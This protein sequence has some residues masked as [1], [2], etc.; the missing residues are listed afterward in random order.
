M[1]RSFFAINLWTNKCRNWLLQC[2]IIG[3]RE[4]ANLVVQLARFFCQYIIGERERANLVVQLARNFGIYIYVYPGLCLSG[5]APGPARS[6][7]SESTEAH[8]R[9]LARDRARRRERLA[10]E[11]A[12]EKERRLSQRRVSISWIAP[13]RQNALALMYAVMFYVILNTRKRLGDCVTFLA[14]GTL[15]MQRLNA[16]T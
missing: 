10:S 1:S 7:A 16:L 5:R 8:D 9:K 2:S 13:A 11:T 4:R 15:T 14:S 3:E 12:E 6:R